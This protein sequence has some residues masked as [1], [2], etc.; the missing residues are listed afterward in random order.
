MT[1]LTQEQKDEIARLYRLKIENKNIA[2]FL[3][4][5]KYIVNNYIYKEYLKTNKR[6]KYTGDYY[7]QSDIVIEMYKMDYSYKKIS[8]RTG[9]THNQICQVINLTTYRRRKSITVKNLKDIEILWS[10]GMKISNISHKLNLPYGKVQYWTRKMQS[11]VYTSL[12]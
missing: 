4:L 9:L 6:S 8:E 2:I 7:K 1:S 11:G 3:G 10:Q 12:H 5:S